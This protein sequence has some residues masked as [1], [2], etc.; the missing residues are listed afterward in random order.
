M[1]EKRLGKILV[2]ILGR[3]L[4]VVLITILGAVGG[5][6]V[7]YCVSW[8]QFNPTPPPPLTM[9]AETS[10]AGAF[11]IYAMNMALGAAGGAIVGLV[12]GA[13]VAIFWPR[14]QRAG[15]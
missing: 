2:A 14:R 6:A 4:A 10:G 8:I 7:G 13:L 15:P 12:I 9:G 3:S 5:M 11:V 1:S